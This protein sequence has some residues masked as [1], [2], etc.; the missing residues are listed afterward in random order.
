MPGRGSL[1][2]Q[3]KLGVSSFFSM[4]FLRFPRSFKAFTPV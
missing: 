1:K 3:W 2:G 4:S